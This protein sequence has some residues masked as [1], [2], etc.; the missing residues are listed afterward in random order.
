[1]KSILKKVAGAAVLALAVAGFYGCSQPEDETHEHTFAEA[2]TNDATH[3]WHAATCEHTDEVKDKA[4]HDFGEWKETKAATEEAEGTKERVC[5]VCDYKETGT[6][7]KLEHKHEVGTK[8]DAVGGTCVK[9][10]TIEYYDCKNPKCTTKLDKDGKEL[11][12][13]EGTID[14]ANH[15][16]TETTWTKTATKHKE[17]YNCCGAVKTAETNHTFG[18][19]ASNN[20][21]LKTKSHS[22]SG[23]KYVETAPDYSR[24]VVGDFIL[25]NG[26]ILSKGE[27]PA[28]GTVAAV[29]VRAAADGKPALGVGIVH[30]SGLAWCKKDASAYDIEI[31]ALA[32]DAV[33]GYMEGYTDGSNSWELLVAAC[34]DL[35]NAT[36]ETIETVAE[37]YPAFNYCRKYGTTNGLTGDLANG[38]YLPTV[39]ELKTIYQ[40]KDVVDASLTKAG[41]SNFGTSYFLSCCQFPEYGINNALGLQFD[42][43][44]SNDGKKN[45]SGGICSVKAFN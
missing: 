16:G 23:C 41:G 36:A 7:A 1:M 27:T 30:S 2:W 43:G 5:S 33:S 39:A 11:T 35:K 34:D 18:A 38:W 20:D 40:N 45:S 3:H 21:D 42:Y 37:N 26:S 6:I 8:H 12:S 14:A 9:K 19:W 25:K 24:C 22:C 10:G 31:T 44:I 28:S 4:E 13:V 15:A 29:I 32:G 17:T